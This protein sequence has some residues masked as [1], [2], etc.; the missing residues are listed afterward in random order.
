MSHRRGL[1]EYLPTIYERDGGICQLCGYPAE[2]TE[3]NVDHIT[4]AYF[5]GETVLDNLQL[6]HIECND[7]KG[8]TISE[9]EINAHKRKVYALQG[10][11]CWRC[12][13]PMHNVHRAAKGVRHF[14]KPSDPDNMSLMHSD[15]AKLQRED[16]SRYNSLMQSINSGYHG[17]VKL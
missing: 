1:G 10:G 13:K 2:I 9:E 8:S 11:M 12:N 5:G 14:D 17:V 3:C 15:C 6:T 16:K 7:Q 4:P